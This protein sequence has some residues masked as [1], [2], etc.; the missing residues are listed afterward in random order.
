MTGED[1]A[2]IA[3]IYALPGVVACVASW[4]IMRSWLVSYLQ[5]TERSKKPEALGYVISGIIWWKILDIV[6][7]EHPIIGGIALIMHLI[8]AVYFLLFFKRTRYS[9][10]INPQDDQ[11]YL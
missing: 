10:D 6:F 8:L 4:A 7:P 11:Q 1:L 9:S 5:K 2:S 3:I